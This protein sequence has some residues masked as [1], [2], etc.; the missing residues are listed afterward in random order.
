ML[1]VI[2]RYA[3][4]QLE[5][6]GHVDATL[7]RFVRHFADLATAAGSHLTTRDGPRWLQ[8]LDVELDNLRA[9]LTLDQADPAH[10]RPVHCQRGLPRPGGRAE[11]LHGQGGHG[12]YGFS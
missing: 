7:R 11:R 1:G 10:R 6:T 8:V 9:V 12:R 4:N 2:R 5:E 3:M